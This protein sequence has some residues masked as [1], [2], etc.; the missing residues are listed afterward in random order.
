MGSEAPKGVLAGKVAIVT[1]G[2]SGIGRSIARRFAAEGC[3]VVVVGRQRARLEQVAAEI[4]GTAVPADVSREEEVAWLFQACA[5]AHGGLDVLVNNAGV[6]GPIANAA[7][8]NLAEWEETMAINIRGVLLSTKYAIPAM[9]ARGGGSIINIS[10]LLGLKGYPMRSAYVA[11]K[12][13]V[14]GITESVAH[15]VGQYGIRVNALCPGAVRGEL[16][17]GVV[18]RRARAEGRSPEEIV[19]SAYTDVAALRKWLEPEE[20]A[21]AALFLASDASSAITGEHVRVDAGRM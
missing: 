10:S 16:M 4:G 19:K 1:G 8:M 13:A 17:E 9:R 14:I 3:A 5:G 15:E 20:V 6:T 21:Q 2:G 11:S 18:A 12:F 7:E